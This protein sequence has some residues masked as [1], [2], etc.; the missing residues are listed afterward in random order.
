MLL[1]TISGIYCDLSKQNIAHKNFNT[2]SLWVNAKKK[3]KLSG[4][5]EPHRNW[6]ISDFRDYLLTCFNVITL[7]SSEKI[8]DKIV[9]RNA[10]ELSEFPVLMEKMSSSLKH[11]AAEKK[12]DQDKHMVSIRESLNKG[13]SPLFETY[14]STSCIFSLEFNTPRFSMLNIAEGKIKK[15]VAIIEGGH[16]NEEFTFKLTDKYAWNEEEHLLYIFTANYQMFEAKINV[17]DFK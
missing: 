15:M 3:L 16:T 13:L 8:T 12:S 1:H 9:E 14:R 6:Y 4:W 2:S 11:K 5:S 17:E 10:A 7:N